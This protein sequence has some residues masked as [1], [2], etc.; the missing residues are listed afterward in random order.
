M[1]TTV[2]TMMF[3]APEI[4]GLL[5][6]SMRAGSSYT[7]TVD[8]GSLGVIV[9]EMLCSEIPF[10]DTYG[11]ILG[12]G[13]AESGFCFALNRAEIDMQ[14]LVDYCPGGSPF[15]NESLQRKGVRIDGIRLVNILIE[16]NPRERVTAKIALPSI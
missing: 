7:T 4:V 3:Q 2:G 14:I 13:S 9:H 15:P 1:I 6:R 8:L 11:G 16:P 5:P 12:P 10:L